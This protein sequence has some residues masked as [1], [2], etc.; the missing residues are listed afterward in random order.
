MKNNLPAIR[1]EGVFTKIKNWFKALFGI[2]ETIEEPIQEPVNNEKEV[3]RNKFIEEIKVDGKD[4]LL[5]FQRKIE[6]GQMEFSDLPEDLLDEMIELYKKQIEEKKSK[7]K[8]YE[9]KL[10]KEQIGGN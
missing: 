2:E 4:T 10:T 9:E 7:I 5:A 1:K 8:Y 3:E 6:E